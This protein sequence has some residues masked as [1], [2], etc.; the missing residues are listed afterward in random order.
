MS[1]R[2]GMRARDLL[3]GV[4]VTVVWGANFSVIGVG[5]RQV[6]PFLLTTLRF[7]F[8]ALPLILVVPR[9]RDVPL[10]GVAAYGGMFGVGLWWV[11][12]LAMHLGLPAGIA[13]LVLQFAAFFTIL[14][15]AWLLGERIGRGQWTGM[16]L[17]ATG[18]V[19]LIALSPGHAVLSGIGLV[20]LAALAWAGCNLM[21]KRWRPADMLAF[22]AWASAFAA[23]ALLLLGVAL[24]GDAFWQPL[25][26][27]LSGLAWFSV[28][29]QGWVTTVLG[30]M[31]WNTLMRRYP[32]AS[33]APLSLL[34]P[35]SGLV[36]AWQVSGERLASLQWLAIAVI[37]MGIALFLRPSSGGGQHVMVRSPPSRRDCSE[38]DRKP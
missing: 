27:G 6:E 33:V 15:S 38:G 7:T 14:G 25:R 35:V 19:M 31:A 21:I 29:F 16:L 5:L 4:L 36:T 10:W 11:V 12:T 32:A 13:S 24:E 30:Y 23:P 37:L 18:L 8:S 34:V 2:P 17:A 26:Y 9:P 22:I 28:L 1:T 20:L 3:L